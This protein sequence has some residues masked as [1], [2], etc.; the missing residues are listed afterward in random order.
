MCA[1]VFNDVVD[2]AGRAVALASAVV[3]KQQPPITLPTL[4]SFL[5]FLQNIASQ[6]Y[7][8]A[9]ASRMT[10][11]CSHVGTGQ[12]TEAD[13]EAQHLLAFLVAKVNHRVVL[14]VQLILD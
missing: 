12:A 10:Y 11:A 14:T 1:R 7:G 13:I 6:Q 2:E 5:A 4:T 8:T 3:S 9:T